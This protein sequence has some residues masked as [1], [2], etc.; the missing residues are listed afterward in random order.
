MLLDMVSN[1][2]LGVFL[3]FL[4]FYQEQSDCFFFYNSHFSFTPSNIKCLVRHGCSLLFPDAGRDVSVNPNAD[5]LALAS[6]V[7]AALV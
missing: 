2:S 7:N 5:C 4:T 1:I 3:P 6:P